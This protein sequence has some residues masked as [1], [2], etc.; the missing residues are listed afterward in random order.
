M[1]DYFIQAHTE[2][3]RLIMVLLEATEACCDRITENVLIPIFLT[4][5]SSHTESVDTFKIPHQQIDLLATPHFSR[6]QLGPESLFSFKS[7]MVFL[8]IVM[9][10]FSLMAVELGT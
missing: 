8:K 5:S 2:L 6:R 10:R 7:F 4:I 1:D 9:G 3:L